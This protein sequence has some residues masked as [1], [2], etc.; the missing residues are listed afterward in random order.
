M[1]ANN[2]PR[3]DQ[4]AI[5]TPDE[6]FAYLNDLSAKETGPLGDLLAAQ[7]ESLRLVR[8]PRVVSATMTTTL[9]QIVH[10][11]DS[12]ATEEERQ[13]IKRMGLE[14][15]NNFVMYIEAKY[16][17]EVVGDRAESERLLSL[18]T[19]TLLTGITD[20][21]TI[22]AGG[23]A[24]RLVNLASRA[25]LISNFAQ[26]GYSF[27]SHRGKRSGREAEFYQAVESVIETLDMYSKQLGTSNIAASLVSTYTEP[28]VAF[29]ARD[30]ER[31]IQRLRTRR[32][33]FG[34]ALFISVAVT[35]VTALLGKVF[36]WVLSLILDG[37]LFLFKVLNVVGPD[38]TTVVMDFI[39]RWFWYIALGVNVWFAALW[40]AAAVSGRIAQRRSAALQEETRTRFTELAQRFREP[41]RN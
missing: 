8:S 25:G 31:N 14:M 6:L 26:V 20:V 2:K 23:G 27:F 5:D 41:R 35:A 28:I 12:A 37:V 30:D 24:L 39:Q 1:G 13:Q 29:A 10:A 11:M 17:G 21:A 3:S 18:F 4:E 32:K 7:V 22:A 38:A 9:S 16:Q 15:V 19:K 36:V 34:L 33:R 40:I